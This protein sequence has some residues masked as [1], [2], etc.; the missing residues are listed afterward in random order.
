[1]NHN[2]KTFY[3]E[4]KEKGLSI[5]FYFYLY[6]KEDKCCIGFAILHYLLSFCAKAFRDKVRELILVLLQRQEKE[7]AERAAV[8]GHMSIGAAGVWGSAISS[9]S[10]ASRASS[11]KNTSSSSSSTTQSTSQQVIKGVDQ[12]CIINS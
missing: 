5:M 2:N 3:K 6:Y 10:W 7:A 9:L 12:V 8:V 11:G 4:R 1:M